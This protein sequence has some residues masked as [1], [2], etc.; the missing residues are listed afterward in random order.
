MSIIQWNIRGYRGHYQELAHLLYQKKPICICLQE[1]FVGLTTVSAPSGYTFVPGPAV[2]PPP[3]ARPS[4]G[5][6]ILVR[7]DIPYHVLD[8]NG[9]REVVAIRIQLVKTYTICNIYL[10][11]EEEIRAR[12]VKDIYQQLPTPW[13]FLGDFNSRHPLWG[14]TEINAH[15][16]VVEEILTTT[17]VCHL[18]T[19]EPTR[20][21]VAN[22]TFSCLD[23]AL[24]SPD[25]LVELTW[26]VLPDLYGSDHFPIVITETTY[27]PCK[28]YQRFVTER[29]DWKTFKALTFVADQSEEDLDVLLE[30]FNKLLLNAAT[31]AIP[32]SSG[33]FYRRPLPWWNRECQT[34]FN[35]KKTALRRYQQTKLVADKIAFN[36]AKAISRRTNRQAQRS[37]WQT[38]VSAINMNTPVSVIWKK[39]AKIKGKYRNK[40]QPVLKIQNNMIIEQR[41]IANHLALHFSNVSS[42]NNYAPQFT[43]IKEREERRRLVFTTQENHAYNSVITPREVIGV[44]KETKASAPGQDDIGYCMLKNLSDSALGLLLKIYNK[45]WQHHIF[46]K[47]W[48]EAIVLPFHKPKK[49]LHNASSFRPI[50]L[51]SCVCKLL[52]KVINIRLMNYLEYNNIISPTQYGFR[53]CTAQ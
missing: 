33:N 19:G 26:E 13:I 2:A 53:K 43:V 42:N 47:I 37:S 20:F 45:I 12:D 35:N 23:V 49:P 38:Y 9:N 22:G 24:C 16:R 6:A 39:I 32:R 15:G 21:D 25:C 28:G 30:T 7:N 29:A 3:G 31:I 4:G 14:D 27:T 17:E 50:A 48:A 44:L 11:P 41:E 36:R 1:T 5:T 46:P 18:N 8:I 40:A 51:T 52:E 34:A 10:S